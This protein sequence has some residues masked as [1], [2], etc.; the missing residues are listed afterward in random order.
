[1]KFRKTD[2]IG[3]S[4]RLLISGVRS[5]LARLLRLSSL[6]KTLLDRDVMLAVCPRDGHIIGGLG[7]HFVDFLGRAVGVRGGT[8]DIFRRLL[9]GVRHFGGGLLPGRSDIRGDCRGGLGV[10]ATTCQ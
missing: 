1:M 9:L 5:F 6:G 3:V 8:V 4:F 10:V 7:A 2:S